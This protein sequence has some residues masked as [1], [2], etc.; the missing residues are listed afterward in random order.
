MENRELRLE[1]KIGSLEALLF[2]HGEAVSFKKLRAVLDLEADE[3]PNVIRE[4][5][6]N[7]DM[8]DRGLTLIVDDEKIQMATKPEFHK[9]MENFVKDELSADLTPASLETLSIIAYFGPISRNRI[10]YLRGVNS[11]FI[12]RNLLLRGLI[13]R[14]ADPVRVSAFLYRPAFEMLKHMGLGRKNDLPDYD[15]FQVLLAKF[16]GQD[17]ANLPNSAGEKAIPENN[18]E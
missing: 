15:K 9:I 6:K 17:G 2:V 3:V 18:A 11:S 12:L 13:E 10:D 8:A 1:N 5:K 16:E 7:L 14:S 4:L